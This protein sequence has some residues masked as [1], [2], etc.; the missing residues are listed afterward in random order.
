MA[1]TVGFSEYPRVLSENEE[2]RLTV[3]KGKSQK[4]VVGKV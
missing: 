4:I 1:A 2:K 3:L